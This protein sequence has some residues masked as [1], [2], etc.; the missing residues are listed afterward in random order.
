MNYT[1]ARDWEVLGNAR[2]G[3]PE[4]QAE[5]ARRGLV[6]S[7][8]PRPQLTDNPPHFLRPVLQRRLLAC[9]HTIER[10][11]A[12]RLNLPGGIMICPECG[13]RERR[14]VAIMDDIPAIENH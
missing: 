14:V 4:A 2:K 8:E 13:M 6:V 3:Y 7:Q 5:A 11:A 1:E 9:G 10:K 12:I